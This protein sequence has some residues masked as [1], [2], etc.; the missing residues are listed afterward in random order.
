MHTVSLRSFFVHIFF[1]S[2]F[3]FALQFTNWE[4]NY[5]TFSFN[6]IFPFCW[7]LCLTLFVVYSRRHL[8]AN[9]CDMKLHFMF[10]SRAYMRDWLTSFVV[11]QKKMKWNNVAQSKKLEMEITLNLIEFLNRSQESK[12]VS[13]CKEFLSR[14]ITDELSSWALLVEI[15]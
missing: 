6:H 7:E 2:L 12:V 14:Q 4:K 8:E 1:F 3:I 10:Y 5:F 13:K 9:K 15:N 11:V